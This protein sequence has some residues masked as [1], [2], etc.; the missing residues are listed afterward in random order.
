M[1]DARTAGT[2]EAPLLAVDHVELGYPV[3]GELSIAVGDASFEI[4]SGEK[5]MLLGPSGCG[6]STILKAIAGF[7][8]PSRGTI[9]VAGRTQLEPGPDRAVVFQEFDQLFPWR[10]VLDNVAYPLR[11]TG[12]DKQK[13]DQQATRFVEMMGL[14]H[15]IDRY[16]HQLSGGM[17]QRVAIARAFALDPLMLLMDEPFGALDAQTRSRLQK[18]LNDIAARTSVTL[19]FV[20]H[21]IQEALVLGDRITVLSHP[22]STVLE[23]VDVSEIDD[24]DTEE[25]I[26]VRRRLREL[27]ADEGEDVDHAVFE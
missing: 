18:E 23:I 19:L 11:V 17:K 14:A 3:D 5:M 26:H 10:T 24:P 20:T 4:R 6:K 7:I 27:L 21:S 2:T 22:P 12:T 15:A 9:A 13:A 1:N 8:H 16:P 25:F